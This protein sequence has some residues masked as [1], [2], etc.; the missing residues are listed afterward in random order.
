ME[1]LFDT[2][3][4]NDSI[5]L[6]SR[7]G[8]GD[9]TLIVNLADTYLKSD[10]NKN[11]AIFSYDITSSRG[12]GASDCFGARFQAQESENELY[13]LI[14]LV[15]NGAFEGKTL[16]HNAR[17]IYFEGPGFTANT[18][19]NS[20]LNS[21]TVGFVCLDAPLFSD[22]N[23]NHPADDN[24]IAKM[25]QW[26]K[27][28]G[29]KFAWAS[30][31][32]RSIEKRIRA[33]PRRS[34]FIKAHEMFDV[35]VSIY[36]EEYYLYDNFIKIRTDKG[37]RKVAYTFNQV[38]WPKREEIRIFYQGKRRA[39]VVPVLFDFAHQRVTEK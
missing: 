35:T 30:S 31:L 28:R 3:L 20:I 7:P 13:E 26:L 38:C 23:A 33:L 5:Y 14:R 10:T 2:L 25:L 17:I 21:D 6:S 34:D 36:R 11:I 24:E 27:E 39:Q 37:W 29:I 9:T 8:M 22:K 32:C 4:H 19:K 15:K 12:I 16:P 1:T 18:I